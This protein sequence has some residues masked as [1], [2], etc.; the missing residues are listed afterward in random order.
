M[1]PLKA[2]NAKQAFLYLRVWKVPLGK[3]EVLSPIHT[4]THPVGFL[5][6]HCSNRLYKTLTTSIQKD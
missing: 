5:E 2:A 6:I 4:P 1:R 3:R